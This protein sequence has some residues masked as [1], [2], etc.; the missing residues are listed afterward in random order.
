MVFK[1]NAK[2]NFV[3]KPGYIHYSVFISA[4][5]KNEFGF[6]KDLIK[7]CINFNLYPDFVFSSQLFRLSDLFLFPSFLIIVSEFLKILH[8]QWNFSFELYSTS[9][10]SV[11]LVGTWNFSKFSFFLPLIR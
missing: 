8:P 1:F 2:C 7:Q 5:F 11:F 3:S 9:E 4:N 10:A 6:I